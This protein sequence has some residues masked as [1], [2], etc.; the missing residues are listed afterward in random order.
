MRIEIDTNIMEEGAEAWW[1]SLSPG[2][3]AV[4]MQAVW[5]CQHCPLPRP[6]DGKQSD[7]AVISPPSSN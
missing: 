7:E 3:R 2:T 1:R 6:K 4:F 5:E